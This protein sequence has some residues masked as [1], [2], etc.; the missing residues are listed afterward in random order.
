[1]HGV[2]QEAVLSSA[3]DWFR[4]I[5]ELS[6]DSKQTDE[7]KLLQIIKITELIQLDL[8]RSIEYDEQLFQQC[9]Y[10]RANEIF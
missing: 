8:K 2:L 1:M 4:H 10:E 3:Q 7:D 6:H 5:S 9:V